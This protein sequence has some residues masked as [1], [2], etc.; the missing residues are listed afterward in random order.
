VLDEISSATE[1]FW[2]FLS[3]IS[4]L[5]LLAAIGCHLLKLCCTSRAWR[6]ILAASYP[7]QPVPWPRI[8]SAYVSGV[9]VNAILP[10]RGGDVVRIFLAHRAIPGSS[11]TTVVSSTAVLTF[12][13]MTLATLV[14]AWALTQGVLP[15]LDALSALPSF[16]YSWAFEDGVIRPAALIVLAVVVGGGGLLL[17]H[18]WKTLR[19]RVAQAFAVLHPPTRYLRSVVV[20]QLADWGLRFATIWFFL[21][22]FGIH[23]SLGN[24]LL[25]QAATSLATLVPATPGGIG[26]EQALLVY[27]FRGESV[28]RSTLL[29]FSVG[30]RLTITVVNVVVGFT[31]IFL[32]LGTVRF[33]RV[34]EQAPE[35]GPP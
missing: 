23:Q 24:V 4:V 28:A 16:D 26:T 7:D 15:S 27:A 19:D 5:P 21:G 6:N 17:H 22:A 30:M 12:V 1:S 10:A 9:G 25:A 2:E 13:D 34:V 32:A 33:R 20:W 35:A 31:A 3:D 14:F 11:Y 8:L 18:F 29:A